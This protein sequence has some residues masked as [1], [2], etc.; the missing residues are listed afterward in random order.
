MRQTS[1]I[2]RRLFDFVYLMLGGSILLAALGGTAVVVFEG[3]PIA[4]TP[5]WFLVAALKGAISA[6]PLAPTTVKGRK[7][8]VV[9]YGIDVGSMPLSPT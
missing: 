2:S 7:A 6:T 5:A 1:R 4:Q 8:M 9:A 3:V